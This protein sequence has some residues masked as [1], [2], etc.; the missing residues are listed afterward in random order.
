MPRVIGI[1]GGIATGKSSV[2][3]MLAEL[4]AEVLSADEV[5][6]EVLAKGSEAYLEAIERFGE[7]ILKS[8]GEIDRAALGAI[9]FSDAQAR[10]DLNDIT[11]PPIIVRIRE[12]IERFRAN[13]PAA[14][15]VLAVE[16][17]LLVECGLE[18][19]VDAVLVVA[20][21][22]ETQVSRLTRRRGVSVTEANRRIA[23][24]MPIERKIE[25]ADWVIYNDGSLESLE[26][27]VRAVWGEIRLP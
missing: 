9:I 11:H 20:A 21:E 23:A 16:I 2:L 13:P 18:E 26:S 8:N 6:R 12:R 5:A 27:S 7:S 25:C 14:G 1:T 15:S 3:A 4:G 19:T 24:Q 10:S 22:H 17:P